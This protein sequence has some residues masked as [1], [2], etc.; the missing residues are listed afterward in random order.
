MNQFTRNFGDYR[1]VFCEKKR[2]RDALKTYNADFIFNNYLKNC[3][4]NY[5]GEFL[6]TTSQ[7]R[8][9]RFFSFKQSSI[10][11]RIFFFLL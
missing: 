4:W 5:N 6:V 2:Y 10:A 11:V 7:D 9:I 1:I 8:V 3:K